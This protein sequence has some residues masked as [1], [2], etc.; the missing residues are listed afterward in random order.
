M[1]FLNQ[2]YF[3]ILLHPGYIQQKAQAGI[4]R[5]Q[6]ARQ[7]FL[8]QGP[9]ELPTFPESGRGHCHRQWDHVWPVSFLL[10]R[11]S[12]FNFSYFISF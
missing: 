8:L 7:Q 1:T 9:G 5:C 6:Q 2:F 11:D 4:H 3:C 10:T 12:R